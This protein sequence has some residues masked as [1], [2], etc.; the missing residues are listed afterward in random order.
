MD[1]HVQK[2]RFGP[3]SQS[4]REEWKNGLKNEPKDEQ[5]GPHHINNDLYLNAKI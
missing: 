2:D 5:F 4:L 1:H 3:E